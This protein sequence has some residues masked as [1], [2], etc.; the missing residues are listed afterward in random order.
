MGL[1]CSACPVISSS[2]V[3]VFVRG[4]PFY[5]PLL[6]SSNTSIWP[7]QLTVNEI[8]AA[9]RMKRLVLAA[10]WFGQ[11][12][13]HMEM[14]QD[15]FVEDK[16]KLPT[17]GFC[18]LQVFCAFCICRAVDSIARAPMQGVAQFNGFYGCNWCLLEGER[19]G[20][21]HKYSVVLHCPERSEKQMIADMGT[22][23]K[24]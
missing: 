18:T 14:F 11:K 17:C 23:V 4:E 6:K 3:V 20:R 15:A 1:Q 2:C 12:K 7:I 19:V 10:L 8:P 5:D 22:A 9:E 13:P 24:D 21:V 16:K